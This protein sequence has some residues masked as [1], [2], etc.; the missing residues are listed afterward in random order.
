MHIMTNV[1]LL[2]GLSEPAF[3]RRYWQRQFRLIRGAIPHFPG[4]LAW[5]ELVR[6]A[7]R[8]DSQSRLIIRPSRA[9][10]RWQLEH[11][12]FSARTLRALPDRN[13]TLL[14]QGLNHFLPAADTLLR[15]FS[16]ISH[17]RLDDVMV[18]Y[19]VRGGGVG[20][21]LDS[22]DVFL[23]QGPGRRRW[24]IGRQADHALVADA[25][26]KLLRNFS[27]RSEFILD[28]GDMLYLPPHFAHD[29]VALEPCTTYSIGARAPSNHEL[30]Q[31][32][33]AYLG[34]SLRMEGEYRD[35]APSRSRRPAEVPARMLK[36]AAEVLARIRWSRTDIAAFLGVYL[37]TPKAQIE[38]MPPQP[39]LSRAR[40]LAAAARRGVQLDPR[41]LMLSV[42]PKFFLNGQFIRLGP[43]E[44]PL[45]RHLANDRVLPAT[46]AVPPGFAARLY[47]W[48][49]SG[50]LHLEG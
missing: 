11:G 7:G 31:E 12:P 34:E 41:S 22:Y 44:A 4:L 45:A 2:G 46:L 9:A 36:H 19:A 1:T 49:R 29:G 48:Y 33:L 28:A 47:D 38:F 13:W 32:F 8:D 10:G 26:V 18:S 37:S 42:E 6:I 40:F 25:P 5:P 43:G 39:M 23:L 21:H 16:F 30:A 35:P 3:L 20:P 15:R 14:V 24:R 17:A 50:F 27:P